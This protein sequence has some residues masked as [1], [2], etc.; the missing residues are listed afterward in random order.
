MSTRLKV[1]LKNPKPDFEEFEKVIKG[2]KE[3]EKVHFVELFADP[4]I[5]AS[6][7]EDFWGGKS[8]LRSL[9]QNV[10]S[11]SPEIKKKFLR[12][13]IDWWYGM[14][15]DYVALNG[16]RV[17]G[18]Y[19]ARKERQTE[20]TALLSRGERT[21][22]EEGKGV[23]SSWQDFEEYPWPKVDKI[24]YSSYEFAARNLPEGMKIMTFPCAGVLEICSEVLLGF[25]GMSYLLYDDP[26]LVEAVFNKVGGI[27]QNVYE[28][29][30][31]IDG[32]GGF[33]QGDD[34]G[35]TTSTTFS[36]QILRKLVLPWHKKF[37][38]LA[39]QY[40]RM[41]CLHCCGNVLTL[42][43]DFIE[44]VKI[45]AFHSFQDVIIPVGEFKKRYG[46]RIATLGGV[47]MD[48]LCR[49]DEKSLRDYVRNI[50]DECMP[51]RY[52]LGSGNSIANYI[53]VE[54][55]LI[56]LDEGLKWKGF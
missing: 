19:F 32:V 37:A 3:A 50:L 49:L 43:E 26:D 21:W 46:D 20:D 9:P 24:N 55:Y 6:I 41:Y 22:V 30:V 11:W 45:D 10:L 18:L 7:M 31:G 39:H 36:P 47:D 29:M 42:I 5:M 34:M 33:L 13:T 56:M 16:S 17:S 27:I 2:E 35:F 28:N 40:G 23:I 48:K 8:V 14:G 1:P 51:D 44:N 38:A 52:A 4:E 54:N 25:E 15:Y 53:P 12:Q